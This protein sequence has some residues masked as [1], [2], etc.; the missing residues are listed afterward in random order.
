MLPVDLG[1]IRAVISSGSGCDSSLPARAPH[2]HRRPSRPKSSAGGRHCSHGTLGLRALC[3]GARRIT[4]RTAV[5]C[6]VLFTGDLNGAARRLRAAS[7]VAARRIVEEYTIVNYA[8]HAMDATQP[9]EY[10]P[11]PSVEEQRELRR[12]YR[13]LLASAQSAYALT[14][15][16]RHLPENTIQDLGNLVQVGDDLYSKGACMLTSQ[17]T[18]RGPPRCTIPAQYV[19]YGRRNDAQHAH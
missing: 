14:D 7:R 1:S 17:G 11:R 6:T 18:Y 5:L 19:G 2:V 4:S 12:E 9:F 15:A 3:R 13:A 16:Q 10:E 8:Q